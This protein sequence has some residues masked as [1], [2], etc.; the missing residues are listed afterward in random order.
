MA[1]VKPIVT[2]NM[3][4]IPFYFKDRKNAYI[5]TF[6]EL[7]FST[8]LDE[9]LSNPVCANAIGNAGRELG[10]KEFDSKKMAMKLSLFISRLE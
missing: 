4:E 10:I 7:Q 6:D 3:G 1:S 8:I 5:T 2:T 9:I